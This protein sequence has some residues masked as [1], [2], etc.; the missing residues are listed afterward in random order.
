MCISPRI[1]PNSR[2]FFGQ[3]TV[4][5]HVRRDGELFASKQTKQK[6]VWRP[7][8]NTF[9]QYADAESMF[10]TVPCGHCHECIQMKQSSLS[11]RTQMLA[12]DYHL[13]FVT[14]TYDN[15][16]LPKLHTSSGVGLNYAE[17]CHIQDMFKR[18]RNWNTFER[19][20][21]YIAVS[22]YGGNNHR[23]HWHL[24]FALK[25]EEGDNY[26]TIINLE[27]KISNAFKT[28]WQVNVA[29][30]PETGRPNHRAPVY[31]SLFTYREKMI[32]G[33]LNRNFDCHYIETTDDADASNVAYYISKYV[34]KA[35][36]YVDRLKSALK[37]NYEPE[38]FDA[39][40]NTVK[41]RMLASKGWANLDS[42]LVQ[43]HIEKGITMAVNDPQAEAPYYINPQTGKTYP[44]SL[45]Y[46]KKFITIDHI[47]VFK[48]R[49]LANGS[50]LPSWC[51]IKVMDADPFLTDKKLT[52][53]RK[54]NVIKQDVALKM[55]SEFDEEESLCPENLEFTK[56]HA[57]FAQ[58][59]QEIAFDEQLAYYESR[60]V[61]SSEDFEI[62][63][64]VDTYDEIYRVWTTDDP[65]PFL[66][67]TDLFR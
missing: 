67:R 32:R 39:I 58:S 36:P 14:L 6:T 63:D 28:N 52:A 45:I 46:T 13:F 49:M 11:Q 37:L 61:Q 12:L 48:A 15:K 51:Q 42:K 22:E 53:M 56:N 66:K 50:I 60:H 59:D 4:T 30:D 44:L 55:Y 47:E 43:E 20:F 9:N 18:F 8:D 17:K 62:V 21:K 64:F 2:R 19:P 40:W 33:K 10:V 1:V 54:F 7:Q 38:E 31:E 5:E 23:P 24:I 26:M 41:P 16:H 29:I 65:C 34:L 25:R 57:I 27:E 35:D 3:V